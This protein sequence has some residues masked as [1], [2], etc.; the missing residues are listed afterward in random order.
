MS[1]NDAEGGP[2]DPNDFV[3]SS[4]LN[5]RADRSNLVFLGSMAE[6]TPMDYISYTAYTSDT[7][8]TVDPM[9]GAGTHDAKVADM[10][11]QLY[12]ATPCPVTSPDCFDQVMR[13]AYLNQQSDL[14]SLGLR[15]GRPCLTQTELDQIQNEQERQNHPLNCAKMNAKPY[16]Y[17]DAGVMKAE[18]PGK[19]SFFGS[20]NNNFSNRDQTGIICVRGNMM[21]GNH[22][23]CSLD[24]ATHVLQDTNVALG[25]S[26]ASRTTPQDAATS[27]C[28]DSANS[29]VKG[30]AND[31]GASSCI[32]AQTGTN[33]DTLTLETFTTE[34]AANDA[35]GDGD[36]HSCEEISFFYKGKP[37]ATSYLGLAI[38]LAFVGAAAAWASVCCYNRIR[39]R[40]EALKETGFQGK[41]Q[42]KK[43]QGDQQVI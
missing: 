25:T 40:Q 9:K 30:T 12:N 39:A 23:N 8:T 37:D 3:S 38:A 24:P 7:A 29:D 1:S 18:V 2:P 16:P 20:R 19:H 21:N 11:E 10:K 5:S 14:G 4:N 36:M 42:W 31:Q 34:Q 27:A 17:F 15:R 43:Q 26:L 41:T 6:N 33:S 22:E 32:T 28:I 13:L 35:M